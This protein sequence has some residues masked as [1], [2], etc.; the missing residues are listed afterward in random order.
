MLVN[1]FGGSSRGGGRAARRE[2]D[3]A[4]FQ[5]LSKLSSGHEGDMKEESEQAQFRD[6]MSP[7]QCM[8]G[9][10]RGRRLWNKDSVLN[11]AVF[12]SPV[13]ARL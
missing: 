6:T 4:T 5:L 8:G 9:T 2:R 7:Q 12:F 10:A 11:Q 1:V 3:A 13:V